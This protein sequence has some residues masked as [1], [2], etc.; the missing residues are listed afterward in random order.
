VDRSTAEIRR[1]QTPKPM[2]D[3]AA[4]RDNVGLPPNF[5]SEIIRSVGSR[6]FRAV[7]TL[8]LLICFVCPVL[9]MFDHWDQT[10]QT[11]QDTEY[12]FVILALCVGAVCALAK[13]I[14]TFFPGL[15]AAR[16]ISPFCCCEGSVFPITWS[17]ALAPLSESPPLNL[18]I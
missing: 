18:R 2:I 9:E 8:A 13:V 3:N 15:A 10:L 14:V 4:N 6:I 5:P 17:A 1:T 7:A 16:F 11:G 12:T